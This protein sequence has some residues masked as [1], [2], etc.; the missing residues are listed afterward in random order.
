MRSTCHSFALQMLDQRAGDFVRFFRVGIGGPDRIVQ[1]DH[2]RGNHQHVGQR[3][4]PQ[5]G[6]PRLKGGA[7]RVFQVRPETLPFDA[8]NL[9]QDQM[10]QESRS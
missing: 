4:G 1:H 6:P 10:R 8:P 5:A 3:I 2:R 9:V 7:E